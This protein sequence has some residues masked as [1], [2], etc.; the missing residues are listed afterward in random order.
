MRSDHLPGGI[1]YPERSH[2]LKGDIRDDAMVAKAMEGARQ[3][4]HTAA[5]L[6]L[7]SPE[8][9]HTTDVVG[10]ASAGS[11]P[12][13]RRGS[14]CDDLQHRGLWHSDHHPLL[15]DDEL[16]GVGPYG[17]AK[18]EAEVDASR[19]ANKGCADHPPEVL[20]R[21]N[22]WGCSPCSMTGPTSDAS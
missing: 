10:T 7:Y 21:S 1:D 16:I 19:P 5:A 9:I 8:D 18:I 17:R 20:H 15:E 22:G 11:S 6:P 14:V 2:W 13:S 3:V 12:Q 4:V